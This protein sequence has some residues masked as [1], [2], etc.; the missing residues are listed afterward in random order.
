MGFFFLNVKN[1]G[2][3]YLLIEVQV[4]S[5][6]LFAL[7]VVGVAAVVVVVEVVVFFLVGFLREVVVVLRVVE[8]VVSFCA[9]VYQKY[10]DIWIIGEG[11]Y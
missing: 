2:C 9:V 4:I 5:S 6:V 10:I 3:F 8:V 7:V 1:V 11:G